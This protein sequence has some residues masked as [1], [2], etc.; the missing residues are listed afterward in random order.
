MVA[1]V[2]HRCIVR[3]F[4]LTVVVGGL[5]LV[6][7]SVSA[8]DAI[9]PRFRG[10][11]GGGISSLKGVPVE[12]TENDYEWSRELPG[13]GHS[14]PVLWHERLFVTCGHDN[15]KRSL[16]CL[17][18]ATGEEIW[19]RTIT[20]DANHL[21]LK[22]SYA[23]GTPVLDGER[24]YAAFADEQ[25]YVVSA[26]SFE[27]ESVWTQDLGTFTSQHG[28]GVSPILY[29]DL[30]IVPNDQ[31]APSSIVALNKDSGEVV[32]RTSERAFRETSYST[33]LLIEGDGGR[34]ELVCLSGA[35]GV[36]GLAPATGDILWES[37]EMPQRTVA[38]P[39]FGEG[40]VIAL[41]GQGGRGKYLMAVEPGSTSAEARVRFTRDRDLP[42]VPTP[43]IHEGRVYLWLDNGVVSCLDLWTGDELKTA[44]VGG[45][46]S[47]SPVMID[48]KLYCIS[49]EGEV[50]VVEAS[51]EL[52]VLGRSPLGDESYS[53]P[54]V[55]GGRVYF[56]GF[57]TLSC[58]KAR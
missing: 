33:P 57:H 2:T 22:N 13:K 45:K 11:N 48:G 6:P 39:V 20:L 27:G 37:P 41:S 35:S 18:A 55:A 10:E 23:S 19:A 9:W 3:G 17:E 34:P 43:I 51:P 4:W 26:Y 25:H 38:S 16:L 7:P 46:F 32:W 36:T 31:K 52:T 15:G 29:G 42:Y 40:V 47:G 56:R 53:T 44:R 58:L 21:H 54:A 5:T 12:W 24:V 50:V 1:P 30:L 8:D 14:A 28:Q 49:E